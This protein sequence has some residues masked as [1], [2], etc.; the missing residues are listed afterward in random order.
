MSGLLTNAR[1]SVGHNRYLFL[2]HLISCISVSSQHPVWKQRNISNFIKCRYA[3]RGNG[4]PAVQPPAPSILCSVP[5]SPFKSPHPTDTVVTSLL[6]CKICVSIMWAWV[7]TYIHTHT[8]A[9]HLYIILMHTQLIHLHIHI[10]THTQAQKYTHMYAHTLLYTYTNILILE[11]EKEPCTKWDAGDKQTGLMAHTHI[12][13]VASPC[14]RNKKIDG[15]VQKS[16]GNKQC[17]LNPLTVRLI[18]LHMLKCSKTV[19]LSQGWWRLYRCT[20][21]KRTLHP[22]PHSLWQREEKQ[23]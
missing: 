19:V 20:P 11:R 5:A 17:R 13:N 14:N 8:Q 7:Y 3:S 2:F 1:P 15:A 10:Y 18:T 6:P 22:S 23:C 4:S 9:I 21:A 12:L 16:S